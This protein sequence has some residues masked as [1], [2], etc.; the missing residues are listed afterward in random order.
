MRMDNRMNLNEL[1]WDG[2]QEDTFHCYMGQV[3]MDLACGMDVD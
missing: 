1:T 2:T 3:C